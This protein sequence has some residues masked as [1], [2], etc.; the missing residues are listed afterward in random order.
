[1]KMK[2]S[3]EH[4]WNDTDRG[5]LKYWE[6]NVSQWDI[7]HPKSHMIGLGTNPAVRA[8]RPMTDRLSDKK[9]STLCAGVSG[10]M[11]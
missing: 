8:Q 4:W 11:K 3:T 6:K 5:K 10:R 7:V 9:N 1:M 2:R